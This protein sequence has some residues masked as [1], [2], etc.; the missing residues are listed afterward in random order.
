MD[1]KK[2]LLQLIVCLLLVFC[3]SNLSYAGGDHG[4]IDD[5][6][7]ILENAIGYMGTAVGSY[8]YLRG[9]METLISEYRSNEND[10]E[11]G[12]TAAFTKLCVAFVAASVAVSTGGTLAPAAF[13]AYLAVHD[14]FVGGS[15]D[16]QQYVDA[17]GTVLSLMDAA[18]TDV[19]TAYRS[20]ENLRLPATDSSGN[21]TGGTRTVA[22]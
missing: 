16:A 12:Y 5:A 15:I 4:D 8:D 13:V 3:V 2:S 9:S 10:I 11:R 6:E 1:R 20:G 19:N 21:Y 22:V 7:T 18:Q 17:M 14:A